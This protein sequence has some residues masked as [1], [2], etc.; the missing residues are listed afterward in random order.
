[1]TSIIVWDVWFVY[2]NIKCAISR[3]REKNANIFVTLYLN[4]TIVCWF[5]KNTQVVREFKSGRFSAA[6]IKPFRPFRTHS[7][8][9]V[10]DYLV[11][12]KN[13]LS[14]FVNA[15]KWI[16]FDCGNLS[17]IA[18]WLMNILFNFF[19]LLQKNDFILSFLL[20]LLLLISPNKFCHM[21]CTLHQCNFTHLISSHL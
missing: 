19:F 15:H 12:F 20:F 17:E 14:C 7:S 3:K 8:S 4:E 16:H 21:N 18:H 9:V 11:S 5:L 2:E 6:K 10:H 1:M 13:I